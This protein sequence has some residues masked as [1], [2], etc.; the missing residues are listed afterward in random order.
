MRFVRYGSGKEYPDESCGSVTLG[1]CGRRNRDTERE[2]E[3]SPFDRIQ[4]FSI[5]G[6]LERVIVSTTLTVSTA[7]S[8]SDERDLLLS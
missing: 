1:S 7:W 5:V 3:M 6:R 2:R 4:T 8:T